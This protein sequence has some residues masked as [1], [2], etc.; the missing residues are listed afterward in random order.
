MYSTLSTLDTLG[1]EE[2][3]QISDVSLFQVLICYTAVIGRW[4]AQNV[5]IHHSTYLTTVLAG[6]AGSEKTSE[7]R[8]RLRKE[9]L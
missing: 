7:G 6:G 9:F 2:N 5:G 1:T 4:I 3:A 8:A